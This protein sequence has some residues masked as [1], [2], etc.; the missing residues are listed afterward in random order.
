MRRHAC[1]CTTAII[2]TMVGFAAETAIAQTALRSFKVG[3]WTAGAYAR[4]GRF[5]HC[6]ASAGYGSGITMLFSINRRYQWSM[7][8]ANR[9]WRLTPGAVYNLAFAIDEGQAIHARGEA[10]NPSHAIV[11]LADSVDLFNRFRRG[12]VLRVAA[13]DRIFT[14]N[15][16]GTSA[17]LAQLY[18]CVQQYTQ[19]ANVAQSDPFGRQQSPRQQSSE[20]S[21][22]RS[23]SNPA[24]QAEAAILLANIMSAAKVS[25]YTLGTPEQASKMSV[26]AVWTAHAVIGTLLIA[27]KMRVDDPEIQGIVI[28]SEARFCKGGFMSGALPS[29]GSRE[30]RIMTT[31]Q[32]QGQAAKTTYYFAVGR[33]KGGLYLFTTATTPS[34]NRD[35]AEQ[36]DAN[37]RTAT[38]RTVN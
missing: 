11:Q 10:I 14:F 1:I 15:L 35:D 7:G 28:G 27:P 38:L 9:D 8:F 4:D 25:G 36:A 37:I 12:H 21:S 16:E 6:A 24:H 17:M 23:S 34:G 2:A 13:A 26:D 33:P 20:S 30:L 31:C 19:P 22:N 18:S 5:T 3:N 32:P 29:D